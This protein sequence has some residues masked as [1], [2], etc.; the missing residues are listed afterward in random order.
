MPKKKWE[1]I[2]PNVRPADSRVNVTRETF[3]NIS[4]VRRLAREQQ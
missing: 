3:Y 1:I 4:T 2:I